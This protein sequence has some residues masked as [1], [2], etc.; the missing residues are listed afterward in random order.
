[1]RQAIMSLAVF[2]DDHR[3]VRKVSAIKTLVSVFSFSI[4]VLHDFLHK[5][6]ILGITF[7]QILKLVSQF[8]LIIFD[9]SK[10]LIQLDDIRIV[11]D[12]LDME[13]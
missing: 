2:T 1:M 3:Q 7:Q 10:L 12:T 8:H 11:F 4:R 5:I 13:L 6:F 9:P